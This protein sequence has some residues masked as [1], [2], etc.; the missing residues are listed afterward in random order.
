MSKRSELDALNISVKNGDWENVAERI[1][2][3]VVDHPDWFSYKVLTDL[4]L[5]LL[6]RKYFK[7]SLFLCQKALEKD[8]QSIKALEIMY[9][10]LL[11]RGQIDDAELVLN[12]MRQ[13]VAPNDYRVGQWEALLFNFRS[14]SDSILALLDAKKIQ[15]DRTD[16]HFSEVFLA[17]VMALIE[18]G[19][20]KQAR[21]LVD[22]FCSTPNPKDVNEVNLTGRLL[23]AE[24]RLADA[25]AIYAEGEVHNTGVGAIECRW[26]RALI[27][28]SRGELQAGWEAHEI[29]WFWDK[30]T[31]PKHAIPIKSWNG[32]DLSNK[33]ILIW[34]EQGVG[35][36][37]MFL[38]VLPALLER[39]PSE[40]CLAVS[41]KITK[42]V[43][44]WYPSCL[45]L[46]FSSMW[47][48]MDR[49]KESYDYQIPSGSLMLKIPC[50][51][52]R[53][54]KVSIGSSSQL[55]SM[56]QGIL[57]QFPGKRR[58]VGLSWRSGLVTHKRVHS[59]LSVSAAYNLMAGAPSDVLF[60]ILQYGVTD[61]ERVQLDSLANV[62]IPKDDF[63][64]DVFSQMVHTKLCDLVVSPGTVSLQVA[65]V[66]GVPAITWAGRYG[67]VYLGAEDY[68]W[69]PNIHVIRCDLFWD[70]GA[71]VRQ[72]SKM[73]D[74]FYAL[75]PAGI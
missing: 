11:T 52:A 14:D 8:R 40:V 59:Y 60:L 43:K 13:N 37:L 48:A 3:L 34:G 25:S 56:R 26:N 45:V 27:D 75:S 42:V 41:D 64:D 5:E 58:I 38:S 46:S 33:K 20:V 54:R 18:R 62:L 66:C 29:R 30:F 7:S 63:H 6:R 72:L 47:A 73:L 57:S 65:G 71:L 53:C 51:D 68:P 21:Q 28:L 67:W 32:E 16:L 10:L 35:D 70:K 23:A 61:E 50:L 19:R 49:L 17:V 24:G 15:L 36:E 31:S 9:F 12:A 44:A 2:K 69:Y 22:E 74:K 39:N 4:A 55:E 1:E